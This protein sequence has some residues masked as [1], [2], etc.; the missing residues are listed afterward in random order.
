MQRQMRSVRLDGTDVDAKRRELRD[1]FYQSYDLFESLFELL[2]SDDVFYRQ[3]EPTRHPMIFYFGHTAVFYVNKLVAA[4]ALNERINPRFESLFAVGVD[5]MV[6]DEQSSRFAW[7][8]VSEVRDYRRAVRTLVGELIMTLPMR[9]PI[10]QEDP[11]WAI[12]MGIEHERIHIETSSVLHRQMPLA[13]IRPLAAFPACPRSGEAPENAM[14]PFAGGSITLGKGN[15]DQGL[16]GWDNEYG[17]REY[18]L[19]GFEA[20]KYLVSNGEF[21]AF[22]EDGGYTDGRW[23]DAE[24]EKFLA[25]R[26]A[27]CPPFWIPVSGGYRFRTLCAEIDLPMDWPVEVNALEAQAFCRWKSDRDGYGYRLPGEAEWYLMMRE[28]GMEEQV[29]DDTRANI[30][31][32]HYASSVPV[33]T[34][35]QGEVYD[36]LG[37]VWQWTQ[38]PIEGFE[39][40]A[41]HPWYDDFSTP[42]FDTKHNLIKGGSWIST[43]N[44]IVSFSRYAF[45]RHFYQHAGFRYVRGGRVEERERAAV[46][47]DP[48]VAGL[49]ETG[50][51]EGNGFA[52]AAAEAIAPFSNGGNVLEL[53]CKAGRLS[54][55][56]SR[57]F[58]TVVGVDR[59]ARFISPGVELLRE[60]TIRYRFG[61]SVR[62][63]V[64]ASLDL[65]LAAEKV[66]FYQAD[67]RNLKP[68]LQGYGCIVVNAVYEP[69]SDVE[70]I[71]EAMRERLKAGGSV[72]ALTNAAVRRDARRFAYTRGTETV[73]GYLNVWK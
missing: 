7:P 43:G 19:E 35:A 12:W 68:H 62:E 57:Y 21:L 16:Y 73:E 61:T 5:E 39:G 4:G 64:L 59:S 69:V 50:Y 20:S 51:G 2:A 49:C 70:T 1:Y 15:S 55:E 45:R 48:E 71:A 3:S 40:F 32:A 14:V 65:P 60:G 66:E 46:I 33:D 8:E 6:W 67:M 47:E 44:E 24:G 23:W 13:Y 25:L 31:C 26:G 54:L 10:V 22:V 58:D 30:N 17:T 42:T 56:L 11:F 41:P 38:T 72:I 28:S 18:T 37:N 27:K 29:Y 53:G 63:V 36:V 9:L 34:F 52:V